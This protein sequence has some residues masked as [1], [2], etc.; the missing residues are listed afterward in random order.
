MATAE[1]DWEATSPL[2]HLPAVQAVQGK[3][4]MFHG[5]DYRGVD[6]LADLR[7]VRDSP[8]FMVAKVDAVEIL[9][10]ARYRGVVTALF[11]VLFILLAAGVT[12]YSYRYRQVRLYRELYRSERERRD[13][14]E[15]FQ[16]TLY[17]IGDAVVTT[18]IWHEC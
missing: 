13:A 5:K 16:T 15:E 8:W 6:V 3:T 17:S 2:T 14:Q 9:R 18:D 7:S 12:A 1:C 11:S 10:E 4:G